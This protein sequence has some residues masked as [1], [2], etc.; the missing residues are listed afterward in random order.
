MCWRLLS[1]PQ[2]STEHK[3]KGM[4]ITVQVEDGSHRELILEYPYPTNKHGGSLPLPQRPNLSVKT[5]EADVRKAIASG[6]NPISRGRRSYITY[7]QFQTESQPFSF[8][9]LSTTGC[10]SLPVMTE[11]VKPSTIAVVAGLIAAVKLARV[12]SSEIDRRSPRVRCAISDSASIAQMVLAE[13]M[14]RQ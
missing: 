5:V 7:P 12:D 4:C 8:V 11:P 3:Y 14:R 9:C 6:W 13:A 1:E 10:C 2:W